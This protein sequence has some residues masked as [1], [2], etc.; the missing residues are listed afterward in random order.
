MAGERDPRQGQSYKLAVAVS[1]PEQG[2]EMRWGPAACL[3]RQLLLL[4]SGLRKGSLQAG[5]LLLHR[6]ELGLRLR[7][8]SERG[9]QRGLGRRERGALGLHLRVVGAGGGGGAGGVH[10]RAGCRAEAAVPWAG[11]GN[12]L[13]PAWSSG[14]DAACGRAA[15][16]QRAGRPHGLAACTSQVFKPDGTVAGGQMHGWRL[17]RQAGGAAGAAG[18]GALP[19]PLTPR[20]TLWYRC[21]ARTHM[22]MEVQA[23]ETLDTASGV[24]ASMPT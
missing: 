4:G 8:L 17:R 14:P 15:G 23:L 7:Q 9:V 13:L 24:K 12:R 1:D 3:C 22:Q 21:M 19:T 10:V 16:T 20:A 6:L 11:G 5:N 18:S 2:R